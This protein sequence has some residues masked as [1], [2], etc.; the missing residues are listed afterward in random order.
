VTPQD[1]LARLREGMAQDHRHER[2]VR[3]RLATGQTLDL[4]G[5]RLLARQFAIRLLRQNAE[6]FR[7]ESG[8][9]LARPV[10]SD[11]PP[12][13]VPLA[14]VVTQIRG[15]IE[16][17]PPR[18]DAGRPYD[19]LRLMIAEADPD[20]STMYLTDVVRACR[21]MADVWRPPGAPEPREP[22]SSQQRSV[23]SRARRRRQEEETAEWWLRLHLEQVEPGARVVAAELWQ[24]AEANLRVVVDEAEEDLEWWEK[25]AKHDGSPP[26]PRV[27]GRSVFYEV[28]DVVFGA[29][30]LIRG[31]SYYVY[32]RRPR[33]Q[34]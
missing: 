24:Q 6:I 32:P 15:A 25:E 30:R 20:F 17:L 27:P 34:E 4:P 8:G 29:R 7:S 18:S 9:L 16:G 23:A 5:P 13:L 28:A 2:P 31:K 21:Q 22:R 10:G 1:R 3:R 19:D 33:R 14:D 12:T 26:R 11:E